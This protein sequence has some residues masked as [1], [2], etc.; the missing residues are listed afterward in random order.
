MSKESDKTAKIEP[1]G[2]DYGGRVG[3]Q[4]DRS[5]WHTSAR[6]WLRDVMW[7]VVKKIRHPKESLQITLQLLFG[8]GEIPKRRLLV[9]EPQAA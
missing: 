2:A 8:N 3:S 1:R 6:E 7:R 9:Q 5:Q 4:I